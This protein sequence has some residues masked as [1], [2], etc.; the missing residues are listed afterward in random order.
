MLRNCRVLSSH[1]TMSL[2]RL[3]GAVIPSTRSAR[4][5][6]VQS[7]LD[8]S[9]WCV[10]GKWPWCV[11]GKLFLE[12]VLGTRSRV[13]EWCPWVFLESVHGWSLE[14]S[15]VCSWCSE[16]LCWYQVKL[17]D[18]KKKNIW[19]VVIVYICALGIRLWQ[20]VLKRAI[21]FWQT[22]RNCGC[23]VGITLLR[24]RC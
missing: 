3:S 22:W 14:V 2:N 17:Q 19:K 8:E 24:A 21:R 23:F 7:A 18:Q 9:P 4:T 11:L 6:D 5:S 1:V 20:N 13:L 15:T 10:I 16:S 12:S